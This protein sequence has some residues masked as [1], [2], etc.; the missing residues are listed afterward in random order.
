MTKDVK[1]PA[2]EKT[3]LA[4]SELGQDDLQAISG[5]GGISEE[6]RKVLEAL[7]QETLQK[8]AQAA[9]D[10]RSDAANAYSDTLETIARWESDNQCP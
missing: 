1:V 4:A 8:A 6:T 7:K 2:P 3:P 5:S 9:R 10:Q